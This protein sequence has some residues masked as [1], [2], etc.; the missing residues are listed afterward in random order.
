[1]DV[2]PN[3]G[4]LDRLPLKITTAGI[5][6]VRLQASGLRPEGGRAP[7]LRLYVGNLDRVLFERD[8]EA[9]EDRP[10]THEF[11]VHL[12]AGT[13]EV[14]VVNAVPGPNPESRRSRST[15]TA[16]AFTGLDSRVPWQMKF[17]DDDGR[18]IVPVLLLDF[19][20]WEGPIL[21]SWPTPAHREIFFAGAG[22]PL[23]ASYAREIIRRFAERAWRRPVPNQE[24]ER[25][26]QVF[27]QAQTAGD[28]FTSAVKAALLAVLTSKN[29]IYLVEGQADQ[30]GVALDDW[31]LASRL[32]YFL[33]STMPDETLRQSAAHGTLREPEALRAEVRR[34]LA[35]SKAS[36]FATD[37]PRQ[38]L[39]LRKVGM[40]AP[41]KAL[42][43]EYDE[44][45]EK[46]MVEE[47]LGF[48]GEVLRANLG[49]REFI[50]SD[51]TLVNERLAG[52][53][54][55]ES[56]RGDGLR[57]V[58]LEPD[59]PR[60]GL[61]TQ[62]SILSLTSD[63]TRHRPVHRGVWVLESMLGRPP[64]PPPANVP[65][66]DTPTEGRRKMTV[67]ET[68]ELHRADTSC[69]TCHNRIDPLGIA[70]DHY[71]AIG[72]W[73]AFETVRVG[74]GD[75][76]VIDAS[77]RLTDGRR[78]FDAEGLKRL[79]IDDLDTSAT[80]F[81]EKLATYALRRGLTFTDRE[82]LQTIVKENKADGY[83][84]ADLI[85]GVVMSPLFKKK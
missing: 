13:H 51:W 69:A 80:A 9:P 52:H 45:L 67:R 19:I 22:A 39:Q 84:L 57:R 28:D 47:T 55:L 54:G 59:S 5:Y 83:R 53:Y 29:F 18:P 63:G 31:Q 24:V 79:L 23:D 40:F 44:N 85:E 27:V 2:I 65:A 1:M 32:S 78:F 14:R 38:W 77:G 21:E 33:W 42:Y 75:D 8:I 26:Q 70:F 11:E 58:Q 72:R 76:P 20:E 74:T 50:D 41:D 35:D 48:F 10:V 3:N 25:M 4:G 71:D 66:L 49:L 17:T 30:A 16:N 81:T 34:M 68:L 15:F 56:V 6:R 46:S 64:P 60:G 62:A 82:L 43:P 36:T 37:F 61:L 73:R 7:R 12:P